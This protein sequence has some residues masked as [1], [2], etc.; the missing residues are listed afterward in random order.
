MDIELVPNQYSCMLSNLKVQ[1]SIID[2]SKEEQDKD[3]SLAN[4]KQEVL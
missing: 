1:L 3:V 2:K 4:I